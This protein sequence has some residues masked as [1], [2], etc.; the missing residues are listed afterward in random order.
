MNAKSKHLDTR[1]HIL[2]QGHAL[3]ARK[4]F[5]AVGLAELLT[6][7]EVPKGS[8]YHYFESKEKFGIALIEEYVRDYLARLDAL[9]VASPGTGADKLLA[10]FTAW[11]DSQTDPAVSHKC[12]VVKLSAEV[13]DLSSEMRHMLRQGTDQVITHLAQIIDAGREDGSIST[14]LT[15]AALGECLYQ[16]WL[17]ASLLDKLRQDGSAFVTAMAMTRQLLGLSAHA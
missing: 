8:F 14:A 5:S 12:L 17:G 6:A 1:G 3:I 2:E 7:A 9:F 10:Y 11:T 16:L 15:S 4:G 13:S